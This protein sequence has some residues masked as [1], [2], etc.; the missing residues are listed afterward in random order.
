MIKALTTAATGLEAQNAN[1]DRIANDISNANTDG[2]KKGTIDFKDLMYE[3]I[4][5]PGARLGAATTS[6]VGVQK[7]MGVKVGAA[8]KDFAQGATKVTNRPYDMMIEGKGFL[9]VKLPDSG[10]TAYTRTGAFKVDS[11][12]RLA[13]SSGALL[14]PQVTI[15][16]EASGL[17]VRENGEIKALTAEGEVT[18]GQIQLANFI[19]P[20]GLKAM[21]NNLYQRT[22]A[23]GEEIQTVPGEQGSGVIMQ[24]AL[25]ASNVN[26]ANSMMEMIGAQRSYEM[27]AK[28]LGV[29]DKM[30]EATTNIVR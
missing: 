6:P 8:H 23:S 30:L 3:T 27:N 13:L 16:R 5:E 10:E 21:G 2:Y 14:E 11:S 25:E 9:T 24:G 20:Q 12:G 22:P 29:A 7:G 17:I 19:N 18:I 1:L 15:P 26:I 4:K 28:V